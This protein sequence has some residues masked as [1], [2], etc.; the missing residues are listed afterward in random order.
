[1]RSTKAFT[2]I[3]LLVVIAIIAILAAILFPVFAQAKLAAKKSADLVQMKQV[4]LATVMYATDHDD[5]MPKGA[6]VTYGPGG[7]WRWSTWRWWTQPYIKNQDIFSP[8]NF[9]KGE[10]AGWVQNDYTLYEDWHH[11]MP[12]GI[13]GTHSWAHPDYAPNGMNMSNIPRPAGLIAIMTSR[14]QYQ[15]L[16]TWVVWNG[17][18]GP[19]L[20]YPGKGSIL[21]YGGKSNFAYYDGHAKSMN[22]CDTFGALNWNPGD[23]PADDFLW[24]WWAGPDP[25]I[26]RDWKQGAQPGYQPDDYGCQDI[27]EYR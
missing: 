7:D 9:K 1:M 11:G 20:N 10:Y 26:L 18:P 19:G 13:A 4:G 2:L 21:S 12:L 23:V 8:P 5:V 14:F 17:W 3:E 27:P 16:G 6:Y 25:N 15:D 22:P 24:E